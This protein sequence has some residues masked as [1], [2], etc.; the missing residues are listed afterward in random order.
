MRNSSPVKEGTVW[1]AEDGDPHDSTYWAGVFS[2]HWVRPD[3]GFEEGPQ[4]VSADD[5]IA[6]GRERADVVLIRSGDSDYFSAGTRQRAG[7]TLPE[8][9]AGMTF[10]RR[11]PAA[12]AYLDRTDADEPI[13]WNIR[14]ILSVMVDNLGDF[15]GAFTDAV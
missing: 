9:P 15:P 14:L 8:W 4:G 1:I 12:L 7:E 11:R 10:E 13:L 3:D 2:A 5:A 6:W